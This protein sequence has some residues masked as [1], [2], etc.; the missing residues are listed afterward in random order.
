L[1]GIVT[2]QWLFGVAAAANLAGPMKG[3]ASTEYVAILLLVA[4]VTGAA[5]AAAD[6][7]AIAPE[8]RRQMAR[9]LCVV[10]GGNCEVDRRPCVV[11][12]SSVSDSARVS[13]VVLRLGADRLLV[14]ERRSDGTIAVTLSRGGEA[15]VGISSPG[16]HIGLAFGSRSIGLGGEATAAALAARRSGRMWL[17]GSERQADALVDALRHPSRSRPLPPVAAVF[18]E[19]GLRVEG[20]L[21]GSGGA[22]ALSAGDVFGVRDDR[23]TGQRTL[24]V[25]RSNDASASLSVRGGGAGAAAAPVEQ[26]AVTFDRAGNPLDLTVISMQTAWR[27]ARL[28]RGLALATGLLGTPSRRGRTVVREEHLDLTDAGNLALAGAFLEQVRRPRLRVGDAVD[29]SSALARRLDAVGVVNVRVYVAD[30]R[31]YGVDAQGSL[32]IR[33][34]VAQAHEAIRSRLLGAATRGLD[35]L[36]RARMDCTR[37][38]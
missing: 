25:K 13:I 27:F 7:A 30:T 34:G 33:L 29:V 1:R 14:R 20:E 6:G 37:A 17:V 36:W 23:T 11:A 18:N 16:F 15:G 35:G 22:V 32:G 24:Y 10:R 8:V 31:R 12:S 4:L 5:A 26:Y 9:A 28:P 19:R 2:K 38:V 3:Q 21:A